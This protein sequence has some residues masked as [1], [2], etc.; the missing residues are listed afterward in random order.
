M[1]D[2]WIDVYENAGKVS[3]AYSSFAYGLAHPYILLNYQ[4]QVRDMYT[5]AHELGHSLHSYY[6]NQTQPFTYGGYSYFLAEVASTFNE[7]LLTD[8]LLKR[9]KEKEKKCIY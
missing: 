2:R 7:A 4:N 9:V 5:L 1:S 3:G 8:Y 6:T